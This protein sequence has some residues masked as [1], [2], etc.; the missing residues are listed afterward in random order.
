MFGGGS[1]GTTMA[2]GPLKLPNNMPVTPIRKTKIIEQLVYL[3]KDDFSSHPSGEIKCLDRK[4]L[5]ALVKDI[6]VKGGDEIGIF[7]K[8]GPRQGS[9]LDFRDDILGF[10]FG[11]GGNKP[12]INVIEVGIVD[13]PNSI[14]SS[15]V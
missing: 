9:W 14:L 6:T 15:E 3:E 10:N 1:A 12:S 4:L 13:I 8:G 2:T 11:M 7:P 5:G